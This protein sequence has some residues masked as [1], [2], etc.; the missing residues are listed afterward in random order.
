[1]SYAHATT[2]L[3]SALWVT[4]TAALNRLNLHT[5]WQ[6]AAHTKTNELLLVVQRFGLY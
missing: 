5:T 4:Q 3:E 2:T 6:S 1:M